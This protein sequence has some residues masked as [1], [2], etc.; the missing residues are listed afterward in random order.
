MGKS[1]DWAKITKP[2]TTIKNKKTPA[3]QQGG[4]VKGGVILTDETV[5]PYMEELAKL[6]AKIAKEKEEM[7]AGERVDTA[8]AEVMADAEQNKDEIKQYI[9]EQ[10]AK[11]WPK[12]FR[13]ADV[14]SDK[15][16][17][18]VPASSAATSSVAPVARVL[19]R[20]RKLLQPQLPLLLTRHQL[21][22]K[23]AVGSP[24]AGPE[25]SVATAGDAGGAAPMEAGPAAQEVAVTGTP[26]EEARSAKKRGRNAKA[27]KQQAGLGVN[28]G[29]PPLRT[30]R[31]QKLGLVTLRCLNAT[32]NLKYLDG[33]KFLKLTNWQ[34]VYFSGCI[35][36]MSSYMIIYD[37]I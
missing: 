36:Q 10:F 22:N 35:Q 21:F 16:V 14:Q 2:R 3:V 32:T 7:S 27:P 8:A 34:I 19:T 25:A 6:E 17:P 15:D 23:G 33:M 13:D 20:K 30:Q 12:K 37:H 11:A 26:K 24:P 9:A 18:E 5:K 31:F 1:E 29:V 28:Y 4:K